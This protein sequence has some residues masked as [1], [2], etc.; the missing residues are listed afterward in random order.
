ME[1]IM[2][3]DAKAR[4]L[5]LR[6]SA[7][8]AKYDDVERSLKNGSHA[9]RVFRTS[10]TNDDILMHVSVKWSTHI[11]G[12]FPLL[13][14]STPV[15]DQITDSSSVR[16]CTVAG[17]RAGK[18]KKQPKNDEKY[19]LDLPWIDQTTK[20]PAGHGLVSP[21]GEQPKSSRL[22]FN[23][24]TLRGGW[25]KTWVKV[26]CAA[27]YL[28]DLLATVANSRNYKFTQSTPFFPFL[29]FRVEGIGSKPNDMLLKEPSYSRGQQLLFHGLRS[30][31]VL[32]WR[33]GAAI[34]ISALTCGI[35]SQQLVPDSSGILACSALQ[36]YLMK[37]TNHNTTLN[38]LGKMCLV[39]NVLNFASPL[40][41]LKEVIKT[42][43]CE[44][45]P[46][47]LCAAN[48]IVAAQWFLYG[49]L[50]SDPYIKIPNMIGIALAVFQ[51]SLFF[52]FPK[53]RAHR[54]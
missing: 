16:R 43:S 25:T 44:C 3:E 53:E 47:P 31:S 41:V 49:L 22:H 24:V 14:S 50:V 27:L 48:L 26:R 52:I 5:H 37:S 33:K 46:L 40:A 6:G 18:Q 34:S 10:I 15:D 21:K 12:H 29:I 4:K 51:L 45:L 2:M 36:Y 13:E 54:G 7:I 11:E 23:H 1:S 9:R 38:N 30:C 35:L 19:K 32:M 8:E 39:L 42:K 17:Y 20:S 28:M